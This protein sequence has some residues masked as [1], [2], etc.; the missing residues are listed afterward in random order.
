[1]AETNDIHLYTVL[2][3]AI[4]YIV[5]GICSVISMFFLWIFGKYRKEHELMYK[6]YLESNSHYAIELKERESQE[7][8][9]I[10]K[11]LQQVSDS[12]NELKQKV[13]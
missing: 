12:I 6:L 8:K 4:K 1:M 9:E 13:K 2:W 3:S 11:K 5:I 10:I 7:R